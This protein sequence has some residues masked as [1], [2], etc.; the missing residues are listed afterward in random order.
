[1][2]NKLILLLMMLIIVGSLVGCGEEHLDDTYV[3]GKDYQYMLNK[4]E[5]YSQK[6]AK[7]QNGYF[8]LVDHYIFYLDSKT[9]VLIPFCTR[10]DCLHNMET[11]KERYEECNAYVQGYNEAEIGISYYDGYLYIYSEA[12]DG[13]VLDR[14]KEDGTERETIY[15]W[16][17]PMVSDWLIH[18][19]CFFYAEHYFDKEDGV[20]KEKNYV[21]L[22]NLEENK[23]KETVIFSPPEDDIVLQIGNLAA[24]GNYVYFE[25]IAG[26]T[27]NE[28][29]LLGDK[30]LDYS[31]MQMLIY[32]IENDTIEELRVPDQTKGEHI[33]QVSFWNDRLVVQVYDFADEEG[34]LAKENVYSMS[35]DGSEAQV[36]LENQSVGMKYIADEN[37]LYASNSALVLRGYE[38]KQYYTVYNKNME[39]IDVLGMPFEKAGDP[40]IGVCGELYI[41]MATDEEN[42]V[43]LKRF[44]KD[45]IGKYNGKAYD[46]EKVSDLYISQDDRDDD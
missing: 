11:N 37:Y 16:E 1:M 3:G 24:Y 10:V 33:Q 41:L 46:L 39:V 26:T 4:G 42:R 38:E 27:Q 7:G 18:R 25:Y 15:T 36:L 23:K 34:M 30:W 14:V 20:T 19:G 12:Y 28:E 9:N 44:N 17:I 43:E 8:F 2:K 29:L 13:A 21:K 40:E 35:L 22:I 45:S 5:I 32:S 6:Q 31:K